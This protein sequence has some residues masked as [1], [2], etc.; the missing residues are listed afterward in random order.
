VE[1][2]N[3]S[4]GSGYACLL[5]PKHARLR[6]VPRCW[7]GP[8]FDKTIAITFGY[9]LSGNAEVAFPST[10]VT[11]TPAANIP[12]PTSVGVSADVAIIVANHIATGT[13]A[14][15]V[16]AAA[17]FIVAALT[18]TVAGN[19]YTSAAATAISTTNAWTASAWATFDATIIACAVNVATRSASLK[20][21][22][23]P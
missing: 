20:R 19:H 3:A 21:K 22:A 5:S 1:S 14:V 6:T 17:A 11:T 13:P 18:T 2:S 12:T 8:S 7:D 16:A 10:T 9:F 4:V 23:R 15:N